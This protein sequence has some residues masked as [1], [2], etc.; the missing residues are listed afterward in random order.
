MVEETLTVGDTDVVVTNTDDG[1]EVTEVVESNDD[2]GSSGAYILITSGIY[3]CEIPLDSEFIYRP[4]PERPDDS[5]VVAYHQDDDISS[6]NST[7]FS[8]F[9]N[10]E[11]R[12]KFDGYASVDPEQTEVNHY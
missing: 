3:G 12:E 7:G 9:M 4:H 8:D 5:Y 1:F 6:L 10:S 2:E 11:E